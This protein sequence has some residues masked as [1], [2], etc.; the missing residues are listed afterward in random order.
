MKRDGTTSHEREEEVSMREETDDAKGRKEEGRGEKR[1]TV[2]E[3]T[4]VMINSEG[5]EKGAERRKKEG[6]KSKS[7]E[8]EANK[9]KWR[10]VRR[11]GEEGRR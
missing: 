5:G 11:R 1:E 3:N 2:D 10:K 8:R 9:M 7:L 4:T 6:E